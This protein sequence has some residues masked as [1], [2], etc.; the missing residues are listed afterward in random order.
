[1][2]NLVQRENTQLILSTKSRK[3][4]QTNEPATK[5]DNAKVRKGV[6]ATNHDSYTC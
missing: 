4:S 2:E 1:M 3:A 6:T 5:T